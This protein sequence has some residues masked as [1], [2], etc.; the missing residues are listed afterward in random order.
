MKKVFT[1]RREIKV[2]LKIFLIPKINKYKQINVKK[3]KKEMK[4]IKSENMK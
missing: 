3:F 4:L 1:M 2:E